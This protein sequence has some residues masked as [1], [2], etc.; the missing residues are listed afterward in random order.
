MCAGGSQAI[1]ECA[2]YL[3]KVLHAGNDAR[4]LWSTLK[5]WK[6]DSPEEFF[7]ELGSW[8]EA[9]MGEMRAET[10]GAHQPDVTE[11]AGP[12]VEKTV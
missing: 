12:K 11:Q 2:P 1:Y 5:R 8:A 3:K 6:G 10:P 9:R 7:G 4:R